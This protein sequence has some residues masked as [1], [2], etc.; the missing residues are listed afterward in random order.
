MQVCTCRE[1]LWC[2][3]GR[4]AALCALSLAVRMPAEQKEGKNKK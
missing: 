4:A 1:L 2:R 3:G